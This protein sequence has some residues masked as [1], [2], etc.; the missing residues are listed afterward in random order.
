MR[1]ICLATKEG[2]AGGQWGHN[3][4]YMWNKDDSVKGLAYLYDFY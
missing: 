1:K 4:F 3:C 2:L